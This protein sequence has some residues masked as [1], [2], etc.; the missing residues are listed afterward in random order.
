[1]F[2]RSKL[3]IGGG[4]IRV[5]RGLTAAASLAVAFSAT[6]VG[7]SAAPTF[8][9]TDAGAVALVKGSNPGA[10]SPLSSGG[11]STA[12]GLNLPAGAA[13]SGDTATNGYRVQTFLISSNVTLASMVFDSTG[14]SPQSTGATVRLPLFSQGNPYIDGNTAVG[15]GAITGLPVFDLAVFGSSGPAVLPNGTY[16][17]GVACT[18]GASGPT[19]LDKYWSTTITVTATPSDSPSGLT[20]IAG[21]PAPPSYTLSVTKAGSGAGTVTSSPAGVACGATCSASFTSGTSVTLT[22]APSAGSVFGGWFGACTGTG[23][24]AVTVDAAKSVTAVFAPSGAGFNAFSPPQRL[25]DTRAGQTGVLETTDDATAYTAGEVRRW[26]PGPVLG[27]P[28]GGALM[29]NVVAV[30]PSGNGFVAAYPCDSTS[31]PAPTVSMLNYQS[32]LTIANNGLV[33][34]DSSTGGVCVRSSAATHVVIDAYGWFGDSS[35]YAS[36][37][38]PAR[39]FDTRAGQRG[40]LET[41]VDE[42]TAYTGTTVRRYVVAGVAGVPASGAVALA[43]NV[44]A[45]APTGN[46]EVRL[47]PCAATGS[48]AGT[49]PSVVFTG[50]TI[51]GGGTVTLTSTGGFCVRATA[52]THVIVDVTGYY[53]SAKYVT[54]ASPGLPKLLVDTRSGTRGALETTDWTTVLAANTTYRW[55][56]ASKAGFPA[57]AAIGSVRLSV[58]ELTAAANGFV[59]VWP[60]AN[61]SVSPPA[62]AFVNFRSGVPIANS[63][64]VPVSSGDAGICIRTSQPTHIAL[65][66]AN[67]FTP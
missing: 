58:T 31:T 46:G 54:F 14:P 65:N 17:L 27:V 18:K 8:A 16:K 45:V 40:A 10:G 55:A 7:V 62:T 12:F 47:Y 32:G 22:A 50:A 34:L 63:A 2:G 64:I 56:L 67:W 43:V 25:V 52:G 57:A 53:T 13:C 36:L 20:W 37:S 38:Q 61:T 51:S 42:A 19:Q 30:A 15:T 3:P 28:N 59:V 24:C 6:G 21:V 66:V 26:V 29:M 39:L 49:S 1:M 35:T 11:S 48:T 60:C 5:G 4:L 9:A 23:S 33:K 44:A 41:V